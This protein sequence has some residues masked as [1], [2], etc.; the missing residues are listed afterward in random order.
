MHMHNYTESIVYKLEAHVYGVRFESQGRCDDLWF[1][2]TMFH[3]NF[4]SFAFQTVAY[5]LLLQDD[6][7]CARKI[8]AFPCCLAYIITYAQEKTVVFYRFLSLHFFSLLVGRKIEG[9]PNAT[10]NMSIFSCFLLIEN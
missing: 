4:F 7:K 6:T 9:A 8:Y 2:L 1:I 5:N 10:E 3:N